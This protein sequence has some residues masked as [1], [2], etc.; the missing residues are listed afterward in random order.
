MLLYG[1]YRNNIIADWKFPLAMSIFGSCM[2]I[3]VHTC[4]IATKTAKNYVLIINFVAIHDSY[5]N[6]ITWLNSPIFTWGLLECYLRRNTI[7]FALST[8]QKLVAS[9]CYSIFSLR[10]VSSGFKSVFV[11]LNCSNK[12]SCLLVLAYLYGVHMYCTCTIT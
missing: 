12:L 6:T 10:L 9:I 3:F 7:E 5:R 8:T 11:S 1:S 2:Q 4:N